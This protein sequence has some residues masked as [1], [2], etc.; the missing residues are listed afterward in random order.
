ME[1]LV[2]RLA[3]ELAKFEFNELANMV[4]EMSFIDAYNALKGFNLEMDK[5]TCEGELL[6]IGIRFDYNYKH[7]NGTI[8]RT[9]DGGCELYE[10]ISVWDDE[11]SSPIIECLEMEW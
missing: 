2:E 4:S 6:N 8:F 5:C 3:A 11:F 9:E 1:K 7:I 10:T